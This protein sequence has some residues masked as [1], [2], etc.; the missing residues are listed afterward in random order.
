MQ[1]MVGSHVLGLQL[2]WQRSVLNLN[3]VVYCLFASKMH[4]FEMSEWWPFPDTSGHNHLTRAGDYRTP[5]CY[6]VWISSLCA[7]MLISNYP[8]PTNVCISILLFIQSEITL[9]CFLVQIYE[10]EGIWLA[11]SLGHSTQVQVCGQPCGLVT[12]RSDVQTWSI[13]LWNRWG[14]VIENKTLKATGMDV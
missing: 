8:I 13:W 1:G 7:L 14:P 2:P 6:L 5:H 4:T 11:Q 12:H 3:E 9:L 10:R